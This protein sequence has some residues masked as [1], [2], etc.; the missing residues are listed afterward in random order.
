MLVN[1]DEASPERVYRILTGA[2]VPRPIAWVST[3]N[4]NGVVNLAPFSFFNAF[5]ASPPVVGFACGYK[6]GSIAKDTLRNVK[7]TGECVINV[8]SSR[9]AEQMNLTSGEYDADVSEFDAAKIV[10]L[11]SHL[12]TPPRVAEAPVSFECKLHQLV[13]LGGSCLVLSRIVCI[14]IDD[15]VL[16][17]G[18]IDPALLDAVGRL[19]GE[20]YTTTRDRFAMARPKI[21]K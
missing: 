16:N 4:N 21:P 3:N 14:H 6:P 18:Q 10:S 1:C 20:L 8:V 2:I 19:G 15:R 7:E 17:N 9:L 5:C 11:A 13:E 12:V